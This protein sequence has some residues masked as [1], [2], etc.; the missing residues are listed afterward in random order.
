VKG[1]KVNGQV[2]ICGRE[3]AQFNIGGTL[4]GNRLTFGKQNPTEFL[5]EGNQMK[6]TS[7]GSV[8]LILMRSL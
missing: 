2:V 7:Q 6:G 8:P 3:T 1:D 5:I 4:N